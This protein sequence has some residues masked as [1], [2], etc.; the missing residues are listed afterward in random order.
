MVVSCDGWPYAGDGAIGL[1]GLSAERGADTHRAVVWQRS[2][3][4]GASEDLV[5][6]GVE[7]LRG[8]GGVR[9][10]DHAHGRQGLDGA[11]HVEHDAASALVVEA[12]VFP[13]R[14]REWAR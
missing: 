4:A 8:L 13:R 2:L 5:H 14:S 11:Q 1:S 6:A 9:Y 3:A 12:K 10:S 7:V